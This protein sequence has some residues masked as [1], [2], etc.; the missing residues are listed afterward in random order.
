MLPA[1]LLPLITRD[2]VVPAPIEPGSLWF[3]EPCPIGPLEKFH[4]FTVPWK[5]LPIDL[6][7]TS[8]FSTLSKT[9]NSIL[10]PTL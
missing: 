3:L 2:G 8:T 10:S 1:I 9:D 5:P 7:V 6:P 4:L